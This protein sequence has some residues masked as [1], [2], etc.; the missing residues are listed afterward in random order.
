M[1]EEF[2][3]HIGLFHQIYECRLLIHQTPNQIRLKDLSSGF[4]DL[5]LNLFEIKSRVYMNDIKFRFMS[6]CSEPAG[7]FCK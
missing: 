7:P 4:A 3:L 5:N 2:L 6:I 1:N